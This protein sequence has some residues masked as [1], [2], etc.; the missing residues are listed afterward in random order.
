MSRRGLTTCSG[1]SYHENLEEGFVYSPLKVRS[2]SE[3]EPKTSSSSEFV[4]S[5]EEE[6][7]QEEVSQNQ[8]N[9]GELT[10]V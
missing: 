1:R 9:Q 5:E 2:D 10:I 8:N 3:D 6:V 7:S 4:H